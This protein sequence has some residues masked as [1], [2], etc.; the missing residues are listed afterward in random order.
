MI[1]S[2]SLIGKNGTGKT[3]ILK[4]LASAL[5]VCHVLT[6]TS[7]SKERLEY[8]EA[9]NMAHYFKPDFIGNL[10]SKNII[11][12]ISTVD[13]KI[14]GKEPLFSF[15]ATS[16]TTGKIEKDDMNVGLYAF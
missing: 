12:G 13:V 7:T 10:V 6:K 2:I 11:S 1:N 4:C 3:H 8:I 9:K 15:S 5:Q 14:D 16:K